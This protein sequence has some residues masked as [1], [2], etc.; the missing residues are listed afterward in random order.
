MDTVSSLGVALFR[1][2]CLTELR[3]EARITEMGKNLS[4]LYKHV[5]SLVSRPGK[6]FLATFLE[7]WAGWVRPR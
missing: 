7:L 3:A 4:I 1:T 5:G 6:V 2:L